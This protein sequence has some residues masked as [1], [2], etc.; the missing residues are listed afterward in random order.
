M[1]AP[2]RF[3]IRTIPEQEYGTDLALLPRIDNIEATLLAVD[4]DTAADRLL[5]DARS[6]K[7]VMDFRR[8]ESVRVGHR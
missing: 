1:S 8:V 4:H 2:G 7:G 3:G 6:L 5:R